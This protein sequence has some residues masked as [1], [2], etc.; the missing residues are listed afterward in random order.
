MKNL[1]KIFVLLV[2]T[3][4]FYS[5]ESEVSITDPKADAIE[6][7]SADTGNQGNEVDER[8]G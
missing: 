8:D 2:L 5:C 6:D 3:L 1:K 4:A 7:I